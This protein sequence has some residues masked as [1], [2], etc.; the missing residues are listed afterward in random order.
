MS[1]CGVREKNLCS[2]GNLFE[3]AEKNNNGDEHQERQ[4]AVQSG[5]NFQGRSEYVCARLR[6]CAVKHVSNIENKFVSDRE[7]R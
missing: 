6:R 3:P 5:C 4:Y 1:R 2:G 7:K